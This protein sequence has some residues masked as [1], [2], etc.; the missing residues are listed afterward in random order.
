L[1]KIKKLIAILLSI[2]IMGGSAGCGLIAK[3][4]EGIAATV[5]A[6]INNQKITRGEFDKKFNSYL[7]QMKLY[8]G[9]DAIKQA[10]ADAEQ[11]KGL[12]S[13]FLDGMVQETIMIQK[14][15]ELNLIGD[16]KAINDEIDKKYNETVELYEGEENF[17]KELEKAKITVEAYKESIKT[18]VILTKVQES[19]VKDVTATDDEISK[20]Y[21]EN[22]YSFTEKPNKMDISHI[23]VKTEKEAK[24]IKERIEKGEKFEDLAKELSTDPGSKEEGGA[25]GEF[26]YANNKLDQKFFINAIT[27]PVGQ[28]SAP[29]ET[30]FGW[31]IVRM[32]KK[33]EYNVKS[34]ETVKE[35]IKEIVIDSN[36]DTKME[37][38]LKEWNDKSK[39]KTY[40]ERL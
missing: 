15:K 37:T 31:H 10:V 23:L 24:E 38:T 27:V 1:R 8:Y 6:K 5:I 35:E 32:N 11:L 21:N 12:K 28:L 7:E 29:F 14:G 17:K 25:L 4:P 16:E 9:E 19:I 20:Y 22:K 33:E 13:D 40:P 3:T 39:I 36:K 2:G 26:E 34:L 30:Q 18:N